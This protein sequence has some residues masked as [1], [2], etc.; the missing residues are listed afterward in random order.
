MSLKD[1]IDAAN[2]PN[3]Q[4]SKAR[5]TVGLDGGVIETGTLVK[6]I[7]LASDWNAVLISFG[8]DPTIFQVAGDS[9][10]MSK[11]Q[12]SKRL[13]NGDRDL[14]WLYSYRASFTRRT[15][16]VLADTE[17]DAM[18]KQVAK[19]KP[20]VR[21]QM[22]SDQIPSTL[23]VCL[24]D[25]Q[26]GKSAGG[27]DATVNRVLA[28][29]DATVKRV[30]E[31][32]RIGRNIEG[33]CLANMGDIIEGC[34]GQYASQL[35]TVSLNLR[36][37]LKLALDLFSKGVVTFSQ[38]AA[39][40]EVISL[41]S[42]HGEWQRFGGKS[43][44]GDSDNADGHVAD[45]TKLILENHP[46][47][48]HIKWTIPHD[49]MSVMSVLSGVAVAF[50]HGHKMTGKPFEFLRGQSLRL[51]YE[52]GKAPDLW[53]SG[54]FHHLNITDFGAFTHLQCPSNDGGSKYFTDTTGKWSTAGTLSFLV[55]EHTPLKFS[56]VAVL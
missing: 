28:G 42:N 10:R 33:V 20:T 3:E 40:V 13:E 47:T 18:R 5:A 51:L 44:T 21:K 35:H 2:E 54:H 8:L 31:L 17:L 29:F 46:A 55:G 6:P 11:W 19:W 43:I 25:L 39:K 38:L 34:Q 24:A 9:V 32:R 14:I 45:T 1:D 12:S 53:V 56:D 26:L 36:Q 49:E 22:L 4:Q 16:P 15:Q 37:Q 7:D 23:V 41:L 52:E 50:T 27:V 48:G 30:D